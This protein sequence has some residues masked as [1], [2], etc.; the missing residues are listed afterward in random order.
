[1]SS[2]YERLK[3]VI[4]ALG[5]TS[6][7]KFEDAIGM[8][9]GF[10]SR[11][12]NKVAY[13]AMTKIMETFPQVNPSYIRTGQGEMF[14]SNPQQKVVTETLRD[15]FN[16]YLKFKGISR[17]DFISKTGVYAT[18]PKL[19]K[20]GTFA[21]STV[22]KINSIYPDFNLDWLATGFGDM[23]NKDT[24]IAELS[25]YKDRINQFCNEIG[26]SKTY[27]LRKCG[28]RDTTF[29]RFPDQPTPLLLKQIKA[30]YPLLNIEWLQY[31][32]GKMFNSETKLDIRKN[33]SFVPLVPQQAYAG[34]LGGYA[35]DVYISSLP[36]IPIV[37][38]GNDKYIAFEVSGDSMDDGS[39]R[40]Y[41]DGDIV[42]CKMCPDYIIKND[43]LHYEGREFVV[44]HKEG[45][46]LKTIL[47]LNLKEGTIV[48]HSFNPTYRD[49]KLNL[50]DVRQILEVEFQQKKKN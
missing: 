29:S 34:Y 21:V 50:A 8:G 10:V 1:M 24:N 45:I 39:S 15:R 18:F 7:E 14:L 19:Y 11:T 43:N 32:K 22:L 46:L 47:D 12:T 13:K 16:E 31:G 2:A 25:N 48:L 38:E 40:A 44:V 42:I 27:F 33:V 6:N 9:H 37:K 3:E 5:Y 36:T 20:N 49:Y 26:V 35:D 23:I 4:K 28:R 30:A 17:S 41:Q